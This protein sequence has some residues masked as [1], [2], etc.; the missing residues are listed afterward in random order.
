M[1]RSTTIAMV[2]ALGASAHGQVGTGSYD[3]DFSSATGNFF[4]AAGHIGQFGTMQLIGDYS[5]N[6]GNY[7]GTWTSG[8]LDRP[9]AT[10]PITSFNASFKFA[11]NNNSNG[12]GNADGFSFLF[13]GMGDING[14]GDWGHSNLANWN[15]GEWG[16]NN[17][18]RQNAG[19]SIGFKTYGNGDQG[20]YSRWGRGYGGTGLFTETSTQANGFLDAVTYGYA[21]AA[22][23]NGD[24]NTGQ[25]SWFA[26]NNASTMA[27]AY[28]DWEAG[29]D[30]VVSIALPSFS[31]VEMMRTSAFADVA[32]G[33]DFEFGLAGR[34]G[35]ASWD[36]QIDDFNVSYSYATPVVP[37]PAALAAIAGL[38]LCGR[39]RRR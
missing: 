3:N 33:D 32:I 29:G 30:L 14:S 5:G 11:Y 28:I 17:F 27:T 23:G 1:I 8:A 13:G 20:I 37:G 22:N 6:S 9:D 4:G 25:G 2:L 31:P 16:F 7:F 15:G 24:G 10:G 35:G 21:N 26:A 38:G 18:S 36:V 12:S 39:R 34:I 19:M